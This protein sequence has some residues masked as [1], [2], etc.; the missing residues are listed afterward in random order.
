MLGLWGE[1]VG[2]GFF[3]T[4]DFTLAWKLLSPFCSIKSQAEP[5]SS[6]ILDHICGPREKNISVFQVTNLQN[7]GHPVAATTQWDRQNFWFL[8][9]L[10]TESIFFC[11]KLK[12]AKLM[13]AEQL[14]GFPL[15]SIKCLSDSVY[16]RWHFISLP[17][18]MP[19]WSPL[20][21][22]FNLLRCCFSWPNP[23]CFK[24]STEKEGSAH[25]FMWP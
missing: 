25:A 14:S 1:G 16:D 5:D 7:S 3:S 8:F 13:T 22:D 17:S 4:Q 2:F 19:F 21:I 9:P 6:Y 15:K 12:L 23:A 10:N 20:K 18:P 11:Q 24:F